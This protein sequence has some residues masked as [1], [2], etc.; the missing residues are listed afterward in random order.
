MRLYHDLD[1]DDPLLKKICGLA[2]NNNHL[3]LCHIKSLPSSHFLHINVSSIFPMIWRFFPTLDPQVD[4]YLSR[5]LDTRFSE[6]EVAAVTEWMRSGKSIHSMRDSPG[7]D[8]PLHGGLWG[9]RL[10]SAADRQEWKNI[11]SE[12]FQDKITYT[13]REGYAADQDV[14][15][16]YVWPWAKYR[17]MQ[18][19]SYRC[20]EFPGSIGFPTRRR[21]IPSNFVG[22][23]VWRK[24]VLW[25]KCPKNCRRK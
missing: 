18:H 23:P 2:C 24:R 15:R 5:D 3:D 6:R 4:I 14:L 12:I 10:I 7:H 11:W 8:K 9:A 1:K 22:A 20:S 21:K 19:S 17:V 25:E 16:D 13:S